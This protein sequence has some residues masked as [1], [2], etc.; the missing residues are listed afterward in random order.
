MDASNICTQAREVVER[1]RLSDRIEVLQCR[2]EDLVLPQQVDLII[3]EWM[4]TL[5]LV[6]GP[7]AY[8]VIIV[9]VD[10]PNFIFRGSITVMYFLVLQFELMLESVLV[11]RDNCLKKVKGSYN[12]SHII[13]THPNIVCCGVCRM[14]SCGHQKLSCFWCPVQLW[15]STRRK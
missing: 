8:G 12:T 15:R 11:T 7:E 14:V 2:G 9:K 4:G 13:H 10:D 6:R 1:N 3:S 5:L